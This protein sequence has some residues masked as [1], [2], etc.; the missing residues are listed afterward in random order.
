[1]TSGTKRFST[2]LETNLRRECELST[3]RFK[4]REESLKDCLSTPQTMWPSSSQRSKKSRG[5]FKDGNNNSRDKRE[6]KSFCTLRGINSQMTGFGSISL[7][8]S[9]ISPSCRS[10]PRKSLLWRAKFQLFKPKLYRRRRIATQGSK[11]LRK[12]GIE[13]DLGPLSMRQRTLLISSIS[14]VPRLRKPM[15]SGAASARR[16]NYSTWS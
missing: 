8:L 2:T 13:A 16:R 1:M 10:S 7:N 11:T 14:L 5:M 9:G 3:R 12:N 15:R 4:E 6:G